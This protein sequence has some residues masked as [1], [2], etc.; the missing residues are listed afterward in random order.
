MHPDWRG[1]ASVWNRKNNLP[2]NL[3]PNCSN[4]KAPIH[5]RHN[6]AECERVYQTLSPHHLIL[7]AYICVVIQQHFHDILFPVF[8]SNDQWRITLLHAHVIEIKSIRWV[9]RILM[10]TTLNPLSIS[11]VG[12]DKVLTLHPTLWPALNPKYRPQEHNS[13]RKPLMTARCV[14]GCGDARNDDV[15]T[16]TARETLAQNSTCC[17]NYASMGTVLIH[18]LVLR[19]YAG[20]PSQQLFRNLW[21]SL[22]GC[23]E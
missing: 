5:N 17:M 19:G 15:T 9:G 8:G 16:A 10:A 23:P 6:C 22:I 1:R 11:K 2:Q 13:T 12:N 18:D 14:Q 7:V 21:V 3:I 20:F 4:L